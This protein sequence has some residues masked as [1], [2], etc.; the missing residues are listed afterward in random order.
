MAESR[1]VKTPIPVGHDL[2]PAPRDYKTDPG[3][4]HI[5]QKAVEPVMY[6]M[7]QTRPDIAYAV[8]VLSRLSYNLAPEHW[9]V[10][11]HLLCYLSGTWHHYSEY[12][13]P[14]DVTSLG[15]HVWVDASYAG[16]IANRRSTSGHIIQA[17]GGAQI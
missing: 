16:D 2:V 6:A 9:Q 17:G 15:L 13:F 4:V 12:S 14:P 11:K 3:L 8:G 10:M 7:V 5:Y 1:A